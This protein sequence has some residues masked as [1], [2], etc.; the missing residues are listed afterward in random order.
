VSHTWG[1]QVLITQ[2]QFRTGQAEALLTT[3]TAREHLDGISPSA[4]LCSAKWMQRPSLQTVSEKWKQ[5]GEEK[6]SLRC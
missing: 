1:I 2:V 5:K 3:I 4:P 6:Q